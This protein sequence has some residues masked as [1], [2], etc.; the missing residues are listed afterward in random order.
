MG[1]MRL[2]LLFVLLLVDGIGCKKPP[3]EGASCKPSERGSIVCSSKASALQCRDAKWISIACRG[4][5]GCVARVQQDPQGPAQIADCDESV[6]VEGQPCLPPAD[7]ADREHACSLEKD[8]TLVCQDGRWALGRRCRGARG[9]RLEGL[10]KC[11]VI[12]SAAGEPCSTRDPITNACSADRRSLLE[13]KAN[14]AKALMDGTWVVAKTCPAKVGCEIGA[15]G[16]DPTS[17]YP[18]CRFADARAGD[19][20]GEGHDFREVCSADRASILKCDPDTKTFGVALTCKPKETCKGNPNHP[21]C[22]P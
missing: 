5:R 19:P 12:V 17:P 2:A 22:A 9:C 6:A 4:S 3:V 1:C 8:R 11:D 20:C 13:C 18:V 15:L 14:G 10:Q 7:D 21:E 16:G